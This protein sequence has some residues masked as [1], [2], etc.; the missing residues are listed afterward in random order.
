[1]LN[2]ITSSPQLTSNELTLIQN[3]INSIFDVRVYGAKGDGTTDDTTA[4]QNA[5]NAAK[6]TGA[7]VWF[8]PG[9]YLISSPLTCYAKSATTGT[10]APSLIGAPGK[11]GTSNDMGGDFGVVQLLASGSFPV[12][13]FLIDYIGSESAASGALV[14]FKISGFNLRCVSRAAGIRLCNNASSSLEYC[15]L[16]NAATPN[17]ADTIGSPTGAISLVN[18][19]AGGVEASYNNN[20]DHV[21]VYHSGS[22]GFCLTQGGGSSIRCNDCISIFA[23]N[24][25]FNANTGCTLNGCNSQSAFV[26]SYYCNGATMIDCTERFPSSGNSVILD[27]STNTFAENKL[28]GCQFNGTNYNGGK[29]EQQTAMISVNWH[30]IHT[31]IIGC[32]FITGSQ[33]SDYLYIVNMNAGSKLL[34]QSCEFHAYYNLPNNALYN[35][36]GAAGANGVAFRSCSGLNPFGTQSVGVPATTVATGFLP[37]DCTFY[38]TAGAS[39]CTIAVSGMPT[40]TVPASA[41]V[42][43]F[44]PAGSTVTPTY[45]SAPT[46]VVAG[47]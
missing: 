44:V 30:I 38:V 33:T 40:V 11:S 29:T 16:N 20:V 3:A 42:A 35:L 37:F 4:I 32:S 28:I 7:T 19:S 39:S 46:W 23:G 6:P 31:L 15:V 22:D 27:N 8:P 18:P 24:Y 26:A 36:N 12:G 25:G 2:P 41:C 34:F 43:I 9:T 47:Q 17:P 45:T 21:Y 14:G 13:E 1:M 10:L 5:M